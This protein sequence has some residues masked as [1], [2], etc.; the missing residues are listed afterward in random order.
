MYLMECILIRLDA[1]IT[2]TL[3]ICISRYP[4]KVAQQGRALVFS[5]D[6][7]NAPHE[8]NLNDKRLRNIKS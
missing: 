4:Y 3:T 1:E 2:L 8:L 5:T 6:D 7:K